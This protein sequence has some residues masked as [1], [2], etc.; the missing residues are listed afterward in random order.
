MRRGWFVLI[1]GV[2]LGL[3]CGPARADQS[4]PDYL[5]AQLERDPVYVT[6]QVPRELVPA[7]AAA[8]I[9]S[10]VAPLGVPVYVAVTLPL[11]LDGAHDRD[12]DTLLPLLHDRIGKPGI[13]IVVSPGGSGDAQQYGGSLPV[14]DAWSAAD[15][16]LSAA[17][18]TSGDLDRTAPQVVQRFV[19][20]LRSGQVEQRLKAA[21]AASD[22]AVKTHHS[23]EDGG[24]GDPGIEALAGMGLSGLPLL[25]FL[26]RRRVRR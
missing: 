12:A 2:L 16:E 1:S 13:Y 26:I 20:V 18:F 17:E 11:N 7:T 5:A 15:F 24:G 25:A 6:D 19:E 8:Q 23:R 4:W 22:K 21:E 14:S 10:A 9:K 3:A